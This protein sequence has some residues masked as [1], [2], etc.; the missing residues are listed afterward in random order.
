MTKSE[1]LSR[2]IDL[3]RDQERSC[4]H[5]LAVAFEVVSIPCST[6]IRGSEGEPKLQLRAAE[7]LTR[8]SSRDRFARNDVRSE[9]LYK[10]EYPT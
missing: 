3:Y 6:L 5:R 4:Q 10:P 9:K 7:Q 2:N 1:I 8:F